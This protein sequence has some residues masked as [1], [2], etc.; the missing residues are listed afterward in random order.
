MSYPTINDPVHVDKALL[1]ELQLALWDKVRSEYP[2]IGE[3]AVVS[4]R[5]LSDTVDGMVVLVRTW[6][7]DGHKLDRTETST[8]EF[9]ATPWEFFKQEYA[10]KWFLGRWPVKYKQT[11]VNTAFHHHYVCPH[12]NMKEDKH[13]HVM[14]MYENSGQGK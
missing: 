1:E 2:A 10:P 8:I 5:E 3:N 4:L 13:V 9:P 12:I 14:W 11:T 6:M 7:L